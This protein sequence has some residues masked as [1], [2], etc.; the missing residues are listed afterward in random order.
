MRVLE[1]FAGIGGGALGFEAA[2]METVAFCER[3]E[4]PQKVLKKHW[5]AVPI[6]PDVKELHADENGS[7]FYIDENGEVWR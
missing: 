2:G 4:F 1:L 6:Y 3:E 5:P 7:L